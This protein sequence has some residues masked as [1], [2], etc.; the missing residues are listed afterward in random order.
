MGVEDPAT[1]D[2]TTPKKTCLRSTKDAIAGHW[3]VPPKHRT[4]EQDA[5]EA[6]LITCYLGKNRYFSLPILPF[7]RWYLFFAS[8]LVQFCIGSLYSWSVF[9]KP[10]DLHVYDDNTA[11]RAVNAFYIAVG[12]FGTTTAIMGP[13]IE[14]HGPRAGVMLG[15]TSFLIGNIIVAI[16]VHYKAIAAIYIGYGIFCGFG[17]GLCYISPVSALQKWFPDYRGTAAGFAVGGYGA[18]S[19]VWA[20]VYLP[21]IDAVGLSS[22]FI[23]IGCVMAF[24]MYVCAVILRSPH[25][26]F[27]VSGLNIHGEAVEEADELIHRGEKVSVLSSHEY[28][29]I[30][31]PTARDVQ[32]IVEPTTATNTLVRKL[33]LIDAIKTP[34]FLCMYIMFFANQLY[35][36]IVLSKL[37]SMCTD[38]FNK[39]AD[40]ASD[41]VS[42]NG[43]FNCCGR[44]MFPLMSDIFVRKF[45]IEHAFARKCLYFYALAS[46]VVILGVIPTIMENENYT[47]FVAVIFILTASYGGGFGTIPAFLTDMFG[48]FNIGAMH[49]L[50][51]TAWSIGG[52]VGGISFNHTYGDQIADGWEIHEAY[53]YTVRRIFVILIIG[54]VV[55][56]F[57]RTNAADRFEPGYHLSIFGRRIVNIKGKQEPKKEEPLLDAA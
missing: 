32:E 25:H 43:V 20:K 9:N 21:C 3:T 22:T 4:P 38:I 46:Q 29:S 8:F 19:V 42:V 44:L 45:N 14:R 26:E 51:L 13:W 53:T 6:W 34:D 23:L 11:G 2:P 57:V 41:I 39:S 5:A 12:V 27:V 16:G 56:F 17:M 28:E 31:T 50:I 30:T 7:S 52:V 35:G 18:G 48:A 47:A 40:Q 54:F 36:L 49:G 10:I 1:V 33:T 55:L 37:S 24:A 15:T